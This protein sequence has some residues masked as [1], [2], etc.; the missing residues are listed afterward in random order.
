MTLAF[1]IHPNTAVAGPVAGKRRGEEGER[2][3]AVGK[4][5]ISG[6]ATI[7]PRRNLPSQVREKKKKERERKGRENDEWK[8]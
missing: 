8:A 5:I 6:A 1:L 2:K 4:R 7:F 3:R